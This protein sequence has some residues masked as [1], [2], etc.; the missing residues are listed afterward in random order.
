[1]SEHDVGFVRGGAGS[2]ESEGRV[3]DVFHAV[4]D[5]SVDSGFSHLGGGRARRQPPASKSDI[6]DPRAPT[7][8]KPMF[9]LKTRVRDQI[10]NLDPLKYPPSQT[11][12][13]IEISSPDI[14]PAFT[15][16]F[17]FFGMTSDEDE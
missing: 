3:E 1:M 2:C 14:Y 11:L 12:K 7:H 17:E 13:I 4:F 10:Q 15:F 16:F 6:G 9:M 8:L 5:R